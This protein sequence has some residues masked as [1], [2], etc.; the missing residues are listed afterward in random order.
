MSL[1]PT[2]LHC[3]AFAE[4]VAGLSLLLAPPASLS[5][6]LADA[7]D[8]RTLMADLDRMSAGKSRSA[9]VEVMLT[10]G[11]DLA[12]LDPLTGDARS[13]FNA[14]DAAAGEGVSAEVMRFA[15]KERARRS[16]KEQ[17]DK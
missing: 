15:E 17:R 16:S 7:F 2:V 10:A 4:N 8:G 3:A 1:S 12:W 11:A 9:L 14:T 6:N 5:P 13:C